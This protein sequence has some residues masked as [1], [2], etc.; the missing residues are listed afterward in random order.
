MILHELYLK[1][2]H[3]LNQCKV[4]FNNRYKIMSI[5]FILVELQ[6]ILQIIFV[7]FQLLKKIF[8]FYF[9]KIIYQYLLIYLP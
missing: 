2:T 7:T 9:L 5:M 3:S 4:S 1:T 6:L 8:N